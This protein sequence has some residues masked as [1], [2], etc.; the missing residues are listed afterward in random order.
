MDWYNDYAS[1]DSR[2]R[3]DLSHHKDC[4]Q[5]GSP[6]V[7]A[8]DKLTAQWRILFQNCNVDT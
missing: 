1:N 5:E 7:A 4:S 8:S 6:P 3:V 2:F